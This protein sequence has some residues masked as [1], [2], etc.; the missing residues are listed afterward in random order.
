M[1][2]RHCSRARRGARSAPPWLDTTAAACSASRTSAGTNTARR[3]CHGGQLA[4]AG[5]GPPADHHVGTGGEESLG[6]APSDPAGAAGDHHHGAGEVDARFHGCS[7][8]SGFAGCGPFGA[9]VGLR[10]GAPARTVPAARLFGSPPLT[11]PRRRQETLSRGWGVGA[12]PFWGGRGGS[13]ASEGARRLGDPARAP[14]RLGRDPGAWPSWE[15]SPP[16]PSECHPGGFLGVDIFFALS[17]YLITSLLVSEWWQDATIALG[18]FWS[19]RARRLLPALFLMLTAVGAGAALWPQVFDSQALRGDTLATVLQG[20]NWHLI[21]THTNYFGHSGPQSPLL[22]TWSL[23]IEEQFYLVW[24]IVVLFVL[25]VRPT[26]TTA[27]TRHRCP[28]RRPS[29]GFARGAARWRLRPPAASAHPLLRR[30]GG[31]VPRRC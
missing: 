13:D 19:R 4:A 24:P 12:G 16:T 8:I 21:S 26:A 10:V 3:P 1:T 15:S 6:D 25:T 28:G 9:R 11:F 14:S 18:R 31:G 20:A 23:A 5:L 29:P 22:H 7:R 17:G 27:A 30:R 2:P